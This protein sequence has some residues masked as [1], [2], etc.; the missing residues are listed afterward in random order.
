MSRQWCRTDPIVRDDD[1]AELWQLVA[2]YHGDEATVTGPCRFGVPFADFT[3]LSRAP[4]LNGFA[5]VVEYSE[6][7]GFTL[8]VLGAE[9]TPIALRLVLLSPPPREEYEVTGLVGETVSVDA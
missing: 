9:G 5:D 3:V 1:A 6:S 4:G 8:D 7:G 2:E